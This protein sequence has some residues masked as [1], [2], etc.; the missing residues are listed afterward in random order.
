M[1]LTCFKLAVVV[2][3]EWTVSIRRERRR[4]EDVFVA[5]DLVLVVQQVDRLL[6]AATQLARDEWKRGGERRVGFGSEKPSGSPVLNT[7]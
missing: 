1:R 2:E 7:R 4:Q 6:K 5:D 3:T